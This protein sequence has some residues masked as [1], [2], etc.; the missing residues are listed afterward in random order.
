M[1]IYNGIFCCER[2]NGHIQAHLENLDSLGRPM[3][4]CLY[5]GMGQEVAEGVPSYVVGIRDSYENLPLKTYCMFRHAL[6]FEWD[7][8]LKTD[9]NARVAKI[10]WDA[11]EKSD[12]S[13]YVAHWRVR[14]GIPVSK[15]NQPAL[16]EVCRLEMPKD[17][18]GGPAYAL[19]RR[20]VRA[21][22]VKGIWWCRQWPMEDA[23]V[24]RVAAEVG[25]VPQPAIHY[26]ADGDEMGRPVDQMEAFL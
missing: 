26:M 23:M 19:S 4:H 11:V 7:V 9:V 20:M 12:L 18:V 21:V 22:V 17:W 13:G 8:F 14:P 16:A 3:Q 1:Q 6:D 2:D 5:Y 15:I 24:S 10:L 25:V